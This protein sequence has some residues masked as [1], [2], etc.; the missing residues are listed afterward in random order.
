LGSFWMKGAWAVIS[1]GGLIA[2]L[3]SWL[4]AS[5][6]NHWHHDGVAQYHTSASIIYLYQ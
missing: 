1:D 3:L 6:M 5:L 4:V 2:P